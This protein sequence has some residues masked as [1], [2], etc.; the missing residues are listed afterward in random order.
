M[1]CGP[2]LTGCVDDVDVRG[3]VTRRC[4]TVRGLPVVCTIEHRP[5]RHRR[6]QRGIGDRTDL[7]VGEQADHHRLGALDHGG[8]I[9][10]RGARRVHVTAGASPRCRPSA[11]TSCPACVSAAHHRG[12]TLSGPAPIE[13]DTHQ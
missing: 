9:G 10:D 8:R 7:L 13:P 12:A 6:Q 2:P 5:G 4:S 1:S 11:R 3:Q